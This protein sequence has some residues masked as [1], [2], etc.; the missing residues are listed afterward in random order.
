M[1]EK[2]KKEDAMEDEN[3]LSASKEEKKKK[4]KSKKE[5]R[6]K[7]KKSTEDTVEEIEESSSEVKTK[8]KSKKEKK[9]EKKVIEIENEVV[10]DEKEEEPKEEDET[11]T[12]PSKKAKKKTKRKRGNEEAS[13]EEDDDDDEDP[14]TE[15]SQKE[16]PRDKKTLK[17]KDRKQQRDVKKKKKKGILEQIPKRDEHG[18]SYT[19]QQIRRMVRRVERGLPPVATPQEEAELKRQDAQLRKEEELELAGMTHKRENDSGSDQE[20]EEGTEMQDDQEDDEDEADT[21]NNKEDQEE[22]NGK[23]D[24]EEKPRRKKRKSKKPVPPD[25]VCQACQNKHKVPH[26]IYDCPNKVTVPGTNQVAAGRRHNS[27]NTPSAKKVFVSGLF[28]DARPADVRALFQSCGKVTS[29]KLLKFPDTGRSRGQA[30]LAFDTEESAKKALQ[31]SGTKIDSS[32]TKS[33]KKKK[34][35]TAPKRELE[36]QVSKV[37]SRSSTKAKK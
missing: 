31:L 26:W 15:D 14:P 9:K 5:K 34:D 33:N 13:D 16:K 8:K 22:T 28:F 23:D 37:M 3:V 27:D 1:G 18:V 24:Q 4:K 21:K 19:K 32:E 12:P 6:D 10:M 30:F 25:Y 11:E 2:M 36:L 7:E 35:A 17:K 29:C 20:E